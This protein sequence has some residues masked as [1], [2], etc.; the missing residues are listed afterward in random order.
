VIGGYVVGIMIPILLWLPKVYALLQKWVLS[1]LIGLEEWIM[2]K[3]A[4]G[5]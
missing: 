4:I 3:I 1:K 2:R 5:L